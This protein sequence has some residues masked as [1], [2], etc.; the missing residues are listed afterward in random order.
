MIYVF[1]LVVIKKV[2]LNMALKCLTL[3]FIFGGVPGSNMTAETGYP[4]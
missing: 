1:D 2:I 3:C 4:Y